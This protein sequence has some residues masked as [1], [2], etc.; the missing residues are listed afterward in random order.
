MQLLVAEPTA[1]KTIDSENIV[2]RPT[3]ATLEYLKGAQWA[4]RL[5]RL[6]QAK[7]VEALQG[8]GRFGG[9]GKPGEGLAIDYQLATEV[10]AFGI[11][12]DGTPRAEVRLHV[13]LLNDRNGVVRAE[14]TFS[15]EAAMNGTGNNAY[16]AALDRAFADVTRQIVGWT[17]GST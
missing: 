6:V 3:G 14:R 16:V 1:L 2:I 13:K 4:D 8:S 5:P 17:L 9:V 12:L 11:Q 15:A 7:L 10:R